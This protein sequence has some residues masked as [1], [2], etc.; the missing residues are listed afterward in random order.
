MG[1]DGE[2]AGL[3]PQNVAAACARSAMPTDAAAIA[4]VAPAKVIPRAN[5]DPRERDT[6]SP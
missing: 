4:G 5:V 1:V 6:T 2:A 3:P